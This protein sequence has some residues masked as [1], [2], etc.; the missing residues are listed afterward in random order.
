MSILHEKLRAIRTQKGLTQE[1]VSHALGT[2]KGNYNRIEKGRV[3]VSSTKLKQLAELFNMTLDDVHNFPLPKQ[4]D[5]PLIELEDLRREVIMLRAQVNQHKPLIREAQTFFDI[6][7]ELLRE[8]FPEER[9]A[10]ITWEDIER[11]WQQL[12]SYK[13]WRGKEADQEDLVRHIKSPMGIV[14][15]SDFYIVISRLRASLYASQQ[16]N[17][18]GL[19]KVPK[20]VGNAS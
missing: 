7:Q 12:T 9:N 19:K 20:S 10:S 13:A 11:E 15:K 6:F 1:Q 3:G 17:L 2:T 4:P 8:L 18:E 14:L 16:E 5:L